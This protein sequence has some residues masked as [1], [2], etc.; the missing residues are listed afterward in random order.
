MQLGPGFDLKATNLEFGKDSI[1]YLSSKQDDYRWKQPDLQDKNKS[2]ELAQ[3]LRAH[4]FKLGSD[5][6]DFKSDYAHEYT[7]KTP[8]TVDTDAFQ[9]PY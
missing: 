5:N 2:K 7:E 1:D 6:P 4:H 8:I 9:N 3:D